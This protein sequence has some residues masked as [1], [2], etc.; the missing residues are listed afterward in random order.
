MPELTD[1]PIGAAWLAAHFD[2]QPMATLPVISRIGTR[3]ATEGVGG[4]RLETYTEPMRPLDLPAAHLQFHLRHEI[5]QMEFLAR[6]F[7]TSGGDFV[8]EWVSREPT[9]QY[10]R[11]A[12]F[13][14]E[15]FT[16]DAL[17]VP[18]RLGGNYVDALDDAKQVAASAEAVVKDARWRVNDNLPGTRYFCPTIVK[19]DAYLQAA[20]LDVKALFAGLTDEF[21][22]ELLLRAAAW[23]TLRESKSS[24]VIEGEGD[25]TTRIQRFADVM[26]RRT[27]EG[28]QPLTDSASAELQR[29]ILG[30][31]TTATHFGFRQSPVFVG[32]T[33]RYSEIVHYVAPIQEDIASMMDGLRAFMAR[34]QGQSSVMR[35]AVAAFGYVYVHPMADGNGRVHRFLINDVLRRDGVIPAPVILPVS[36]VIT[37]DAGERRAYA[38]VLDTVSA[39]LMKV[40]RGN[41]S[42]ASTRTH[43]PDGIFSNLQFNGVDIA[44][45]LWRHLDLTAHVAYLSKII[46]RTITEQMREESKYLRGHAQARNALKEVVEMPDEQAD[47]VL[48]SIEQNKGQ[49]SNVLAK[50]MPVL[51]RA[52]V[53]AAVV[54]AVE[55]GLRSEAPPDPHV[56]ERYHPTKPAGK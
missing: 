32:E 53:W 5:P 40:V 39:P 21:G 24:F 25:R 55:A 14:Y 54:E 47:R 51:E 6:L 48:R 50:E 16:G 33:V 4:F 49:L 3:R 52:G 9:G 28:E 29:E 37:D 43:Y 46:E 26:G 10:A 41:V 23:M 22:E 15:W 17:Q 34:T 27:G 36:A 20:G 8:Q 38:R 44:R 7:G 42:F 31:I 56:V 1:N 12:A 19:T 13:L 30:D 11:R 2:V 45:P 18:E 35:S